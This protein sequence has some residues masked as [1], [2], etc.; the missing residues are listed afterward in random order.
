MLK[1]SSLKNKGVLCKSCCKYCSYCITTTATL[2][3][4]LFLEDGLKTSG[5]CAN[6]NLNDEKLQFCHGN[7]SMFC[8][9]PLTSLSLSFSCLCFPIMPLARS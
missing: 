6:C 3:L 2:L 7:C 4:F 5:G 1:T 8:L 9:G